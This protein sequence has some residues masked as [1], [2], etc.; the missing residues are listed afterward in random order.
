[1]QVIKS[2]GEFQ[3]FNSKKIYSSIREAGGSK[4]LAKG[5]AQYIKSKYHDKIG[6]QEILKLLLNYLKSEPGVAQRYDLKRAIMSL[7]PSGFP[8]E[9]FFARLLEFYGYEVQTGNKLKGR[10]IIHEVDI[11]AKK[12]NKKWMV[13]CKYH[14]EVGTITRLQPAMYTHARFL[15]LERQN[16]NQAWLVTNTNCS[17]DALQYAK[18]VGL[19][20]TS[21]KYPKEESLL[22]LIEKRKIYPITILKSLH[23]LVR[24]KLYALKLVV[25]NDLLNKDINWLIQNTGLN[26][27]KIENILNELKV[28]LK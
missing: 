1:M 15:D 4:K 6:T 28:I 12:N 17:I 20:I 22:K 21:W 9:D 23:P 10:R 7:G 13:E 18:G 19:K 25:A 11:V 14:N 26:K 2:S 3:N 24:E 16:F 27:R 5:A 8:F